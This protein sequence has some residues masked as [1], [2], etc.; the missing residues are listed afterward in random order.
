MAAVTGMMTVPAV[1]PIRTEAD[2]VLAIKE[3]RALWGAEPDSEEGDRLDILTDLVEVYEN[4]HHLLDMPDPIEAIKQRMVEKGVSREDLGRVIQGSSGRVSE[5]LNRQRRL[6]IN[7]IRAL[8]PALG[9]SYEC[10]CQNY[11]LSK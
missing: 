4:R 5:I 6:T 3:I 11:G 2:H 1:R 7:M 8:V 9:L 10:L